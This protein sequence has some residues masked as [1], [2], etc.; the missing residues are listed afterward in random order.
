[1]SPPDS[2]E[3]RAVADLLGAYAD[4][5]LRAADL[6]R[7]EA[8]L[9]AC[10]RCR[11]E[12]LLQTGIRAR[13]AAEREHSAPEALRDRIRGDIRELAAGQRIPAAP[14][15]RSGFLRRA[16][17]WAGWA[18][19]AV[20]AA[21]LLLGER[22]DPR[23]PTDVAVRAPD[24]VRV[25]MVRDALLDYRRLVRNDLPVGGAALEEVEAQVPFPVTPLRSPQARLIGAWTTRI[26]GE[27]AA[28]L[29]YR[30]RD[31]VVVQY[32]VSEALFFAPPEVRGAVASRGR[33][34]TSVGEQGV[35][36][37]PGAGNGSIVIGDVP[38]GELAGLGS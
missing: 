4:G 37:W 12:V 36:A 28:V 11:R 1:M 8:H 16:V 14:P 27:P 25:P 20:L 10:E 18:L 2:A 15:R 31:R 3:H 19:A 6:R 34:A 23:R 17:P 38:P 24:T 26:Q 9:A 21:L 35:L 5:E 32:V 22:A 33:Y 7:V 13:L 29:A 30:W